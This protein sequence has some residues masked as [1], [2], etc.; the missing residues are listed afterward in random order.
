MK[1]DAVVAGERDAHALR[2]E[3]DALDR[4]R[5]GEGLQRTVGKPHMRLPAGRKACRSARPGGHGGDPLAADRGEFGDRSLRIHPREAAVLAA[6]QQGRAGLVHR[7]RR[8][9]VVG[10]DGGVAA[11]KPVDRAVR[12]REDR[13]FAEEGGGHAM[14]AEIE[15]R[16]C[17]HGVG[18]ASQ[19][20]KPSSSLSRSRSRPMKTRRLS[21][22]SPS[23]HGRWWS[24]ST[25][26]W[27]PCTT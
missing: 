21:R 16:D 17:R 5:L 22:R 8:N 15:G 3:G 23:F 10:L 6:A 11:G 13:R 27:T 19:A 4:A 24:P 18:Y 25:I 7:R 9:A 14:A 20:R 26:M 2:R 12:Q 1:G